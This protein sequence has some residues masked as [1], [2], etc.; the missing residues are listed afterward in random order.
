MFFQLPLAPPLRDAHAFRA[1]GPA[2][3]TSASPDQ[4]N[5][6]VMRVYRPRVQVMGS[7]EAPYIA[8]TVSTVIADT[9]QRRA[10]ASDPAAVIIDNILLMRRSRA[11]LEAANTQL[12]ARSH[13]IGLALEPVPA[14]SDTHLEHARRN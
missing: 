3:A 12:L 5:P 11:V 1:L 13:R 7:R 14:K 10:S 9:P 4:P 6:P 2:H 8:Q